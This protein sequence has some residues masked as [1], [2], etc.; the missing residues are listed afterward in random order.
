[1]SR[2]QYLPSVWTLRCAW[3]DWFLVVGARGARGNDPGAGVEAA[4]R[5]QEHVEHEH[6]R[7]WREYVHMVAAENPE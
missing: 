5:M 7:T 2:R 6:D 1:V 3:C 4:V